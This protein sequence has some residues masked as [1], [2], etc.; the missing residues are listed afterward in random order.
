[1]KSTWGIFIRSLRSWYEERLEAPTFHCHAFQFY[2]P[3]K[4]CLLFIAMFSFSTIFY[5]VCSEMLSTH[6][7]IVMK[8]EL[9]S[10][11]V[12]NM[13][14]QTACSVDLRFKPDM[15]LRHG[16]AYW[17]KYD[18]LIMAGS[19]Q[20]CHHDLFSSLLSWTVNCINQ[21]DADLSPITFLLFDTV[22][23]VLH[24]F[25]KKFAAREV[26]LTIK[27]Y[28]SWQR[29]FTDAKYKS[30]YAGHCGWG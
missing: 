12:L 17:I 11:F 20:V 28:S 15:M 4:A 23:T 22:L 10:Y 26:P 5:C 6:Y 3:V 21:Q 1:M 29:P 24:I 14:Q 7:I 9:F 2:A 8:W 25:S 19:T 13:L 27:S 30:L 16:M 18:K